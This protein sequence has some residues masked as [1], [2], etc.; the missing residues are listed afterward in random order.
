[1]QKGI[2]K[3]SIVVAILLLFFGAGVLPSISANSVTNYGKNSAPVLLSDLIAYW[4]FNEGSGTILHDISGNGNDGEI[5]DCAWVTGQSGTALDFSNYNSEVDNIPDSLDDEITDYLAVE[6]WIQWH[7]PGYNPNVGYIIDCRSSV[8]GFI[9]FI[10]FGKL[11]FQ[12]RNGG[13]QPEVHG[14]SSIPLN[15]WVHV[16]AVY[17]DEADSLSVYI[18]DQLDGTLTTPYSYNDN[19][20]MYPTIGN[21]VWG[22][23][24][25]NF[26]GVIDELMIWKSADHNYPPIADFTWTPQEPFSNQPIIFDAS[27]SEDPDGT[28]ELYEWDWNNDGQ[29]EEGYS[30]PT[31]THMWPHQGSYNIRL[32]VTDNDGDTDTQTKTIVITNQPPGTP[33][34]TGP[35]TGNT[36]TACLWN[37]TSVDPDNDDISYLIDWGDGNISDWY[38]FYN[39]GEAMSQSHVYEADGTYVIK[40]K[41][42]DIYG[43]ESNWGTLTVT[44]P[45]LIDLDVLPSTRILFNTNMN[46]RET[47][48]LTTDLVAYWD[49]NEGSGTILHDVSGNGNN[50]EIYDCAWVTGHSGTALDFSSDES[51]V[52][53]IPDSL[54]DVITDYIA[55]DCWIQW[56]GPGYNPNVCYIIDCRSSSGGFIFFI[57][58]GKLAFQIR[59]GPNQPEVH[60]VSN[61][62]INEWV[63]VKAIYDDEAD[64]LSVY[65]NDQLD[66]TLTTTYSYND[67]TA[68]Y[69][70][71]GNN[72]WFGEFANFNGII[73]EL[74]IWKSNPN[75]P[76]GTPTI[77]GPS[78]GNTGTATVWN[79]TAEDPDNDDISYQ[80]DWGDGTVSPWFGPYNSGEVMP[81]SHAYDADGTYVIKSKVKDIYGAESDWGTLTVTMPYSVDLQLIHVFIEMMERFL[82]SFP[83][84]WHLVGY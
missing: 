16:K 64:S 4:D 8:G 83:V 55:I 77:T 47:T 15:E 1:M 51:G 74:M 36:G 59:N 66:G 82:N 28:I 54:D 10:Q 73:D 71:I 84:L 49:F 41:A 56:H 3:K 22:G 69:P 32:Q 33:T 6:C 29:Y 65:I 9:F 7:G 50:G 11:A 31:A 37:F 62:P 5:Y 48:V 2:I 78:T 75:Q 70:A 35:S 18:N 68:M 67:N 24:W 42:K 34:I 46:T 17:D 21:N 13:N 38:G 58:F 43:D 30:N 39:S 52:Y 45:Y 12:I 20:A 25:A 53:D 26:N 76:P 79:F 57:Q 23:E 63:H 14:L 44:M 60:G 19:T 27:T 61:I 80:I 81:Q 72:V 40:S